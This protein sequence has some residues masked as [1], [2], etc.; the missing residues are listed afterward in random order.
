MAIYALSTVP[1][2]QKL[3]GLATQVWFADD[4]AAAGSLA[5]LLVWWKQLFGLGPGYGY[6]VNA[7][8]SW[9]VVKEDYH[10]TACTLFAGTSLCITT[11]GRPYL[12]AP[13]GSPEFK[14]TFL[15]ERVC[16]WQ[17]DVIQLSN[18]VSSQPHAAYST[19]IHGLSSRWTFLTIGLRVICPL[20]S[21]PLRRLFV[22]TCY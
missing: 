22:C 6:Y 20:N 2:I 10:D 21:L 7:S 4:A 12:G 16:Q 13:L 19:M 5:D 15:Q 17:N 18:F 8:K 9:L 1:L 14:S 11:E 3:D